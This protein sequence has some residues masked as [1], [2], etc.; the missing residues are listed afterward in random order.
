MDLFLQV[1]ML[2]RVLPLV[3]LLLLSKVNS[4]AG[5]TL[6]FPI[7]PPNK[8]VDISTACNGTTMEITVVMDQPYKGMISAKDFS[9]ECGLLGSMRNVMRLTLP[10][11]GCGVRLAVNSSDGRLYY[12]VSLV[13]QQDKLLRQVTDQEV[14]VRCFLQEQALGFQSEPM[15]EALRN[16]AA[17]EET[18]DNR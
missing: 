6:R 10:S 15:F 9:H 4:D 13:V 16:E 11:A 14:V 3:F 18:K 5:K 2:L 7:N 17:Q 1:L 8:V 12:L